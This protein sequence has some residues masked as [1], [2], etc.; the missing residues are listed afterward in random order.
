MRIRSLSLEQ[1]RNYPRLDLTFADGEAVQLFVGENGSG[2]TNIL[3]AAAILSFTKSFLPAEEQDIVTW[4]TEFY[5]VRAQVETDNGEQRELEVVSQI[6]PRR[7]KACFLNGVRRSIS[8]MVGELPL[9]VFLP[10]DLSLFT[11][12]PAERRR[13]L[14]QILC[15]VSP[16]YVEALLEY[17]KF[18]KQ[19]NALLRAIRDGTGRIEDLGTWDAGLADRGSII[20]LL[21]LELMETFGLTLENEVQELGELWEDVAIVYERGSL[22]RDRAALCKELK[23]L[24]TQNAERDVLLQATTVGPH[25]DDW[26][27]SVEGRPLQAFASRGQQRVAVLAL[28]FLETSYIELRKGEKPVILLDDIFSELDAN[29]RERVTGAFRDHQV[30]MTATE[31]PTEEARIWQVSE[32]KV[33]S[34]AVSV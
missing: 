26:H 28:L 22:C 17:Q 23:D 21:R 15:Q 29:H 1:F 10:Q 8:H 16:E 11:G 2:K 9:V 18:L 33:R 14:D 19:R 25:R 7:Q 12:P 27:F 3:E 5:R 34:N 31:A 13:Y 32:G 4:G 20:T 24:L 30:F 6:T